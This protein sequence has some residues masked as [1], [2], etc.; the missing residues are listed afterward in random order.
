MPLPATN[1]SRSSA[2][3]PSCKGG[4]GGDRAPIGQGRNKPAPRSGM[5]IARTGSGSSGGAP[6]RPGCS[7]AQRCRQSQ[8]WRGTPQAGLAAG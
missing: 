6:L 7:A 3:K 8:R 1:S 5:H 4:C 2:K